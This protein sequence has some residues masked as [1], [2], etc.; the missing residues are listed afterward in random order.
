MILSYL[1]LVPKLC[2]CPGPN[3]AYFDKVVTLKTMTDHI[4]GRLSIVNE[5]TRPNLFVKELQLYV[6]YLKNMIAETPKP[7]TEKQMKY[8]QLFQQNLD[9]GITYYKQLYSD[10][11]VKV[12][13]L[14]NDVLEELNQIRT[15]LNE[16]ALVSA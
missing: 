9:E 4:Y 16:P 12:A 14:K 7:Y 2:F 1:L 10:F 3:I 6:D 8:Y 13:V 5:A 11:E 15:E